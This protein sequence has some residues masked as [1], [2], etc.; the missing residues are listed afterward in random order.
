M[1]EQHP[2][3]NEPNHVSITP[4]QSYFWKKPGGSTRYDPNYWDRK[5][6]RFLY[7]RKRFPGMTELW[8]PH[9]KKEELEN[10]GPFLTT[11]WRGVLHTT[12]GSS[13]AGALAAYKANRSA[14]HFTVSFEGGV[15]RCWQHVPI[16]RAARALKNTFGGVE[17]NRTRCIQIE[18]V[19]RAATSGSLPPAYLDGI[20]RLMRWVE[21]QTGLPR[22]GP[23]RAFAHKYGQSG[24]RFTFAEWKTFSGWCGHCHVPENT[25]WDPGTIDIT[26]LLQVSIGVKPMYDPPL[27]VKIV[28]IRK[29]PYTPEGVYIIG[30]DGAVFAELGAVFYGGVNGMPAFVG[31]LAADI[32][33]PGHPLFIPGYKYMIVATSGEVYGCPH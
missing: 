14:P 27:P 16:D 12:E 32:I 28:A 30:Q 6:Q 4:S 25:H 11:S 15:F 1:E 17:T 21:Y 18:I 13:Y 22:T 31:R 5:Y 23:G 7:H 29:D 9:A 26:A 3:T 8:Y 20:G 10:S 19:G 2:T 24:L 33:F